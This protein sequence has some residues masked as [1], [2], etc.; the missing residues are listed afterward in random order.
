MRWD[1]KE[2]KATKSNDI[3]WSPVGRYLRNISDYE[4]EIGY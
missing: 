2:A 1:E 4:L 3:D